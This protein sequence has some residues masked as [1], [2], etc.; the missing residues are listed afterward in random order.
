MVLQGAGYLPS[1]STGKNLRRWGSGGAPTS[2]RFG[3]FQLFDASVGFRKDVR[4]TMPLIGLGSI[5]QIISATGLPI[6][7]DE[8]HRALLLKY[9]GIVLEDL[10]LRA[11]SKAPV[12]RDQYKEI[13]KQH[14]A[15]RDSLVRLQGTSDPPPLPEDVALEAE[16]FRDPWL[17]WLARVR[18]L[19]DAAGE[20]G[21]RS[22]ANRDATGD[23]IAIYRALY[24]RKPSAK[25]TSA[26]KAPPTLRFVDACMVEVRRASALRGAKMNSPYFGVPKVSTLEKWLASPTQMSSAQAEYRLEK[27]L[28]QKDKSEKVSS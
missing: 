4:L 19:D 8:R 27:F 7:A 28:R 24:Q 18:F 22:S 11:P 15:F 13:E 26:D 3:K 6:K 17:G 21:R 2:T 10:V 12:S 20:H 16:Q 9:L 25:T 23:L 14:R 5:E 1:W